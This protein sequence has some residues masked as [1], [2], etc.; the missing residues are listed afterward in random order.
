MHATGL[1]WNRY[2]SSDEISSGVM[3]GRVSALALM[4]YTVGVPLLLLGL[5]TCGAQAKDVAD[6]ELEGERE[7]GKGGVTM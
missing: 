3:D 2:W 7:E 6:L 4:I 5:S 1:D